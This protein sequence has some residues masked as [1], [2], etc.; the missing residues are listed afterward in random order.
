MVSLES[1]TLHYA[2]LTNDE[3]YISEFDLDFE[4]QTSKSGYYLNFLR[5]PDSEK[6][7]SISS[8]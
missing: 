8:L 1:I 4:G 5:I 6:L 3:A 7:K 2:Y